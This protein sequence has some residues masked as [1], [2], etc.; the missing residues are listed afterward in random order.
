MYH[1]I[2]K[3]TSTIT[4]LRVVFDAS[5]KTQSGRS[6]KYVLLVGPVIQQDLFSILSRFR[7]FRFVINADI[8][9][10]YRQVLVCPSQRC[11][12]HVLWWDTPQQ[13]LKTFE[14]IT[15]TYGTAPASFLATRALKKLAEERA[16]LYPLKASIV[17]RDFYVDDMLSGVSTL[18]EAL[19]LK[20]H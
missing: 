8:A 15:L 11:L 7:T 16:T 2:L 12:Q 5:C 10:M 1:A 9:K 20:R 13:E 6:L 3:D 18:D 17:L 4:K 14:F 19:E